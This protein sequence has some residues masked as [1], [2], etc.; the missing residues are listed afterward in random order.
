MKAGRDDLLIL[1]QDCGARL[2]KS[3]IREC[4]FL[5][6][7]RTHSLIGSVSVGTPF[8]AI[9]NRCDT[10]THGIIGAMCQCE[11]Q[12]IDID[13]VDDKNASSKVIDLF[14]RRDVIRASLG[15]IRQELSS[16][17]EEIV[18]IIKGSGGARSQ[19]L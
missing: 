1:E 19:S 16:R 4:D 13:I 17:I 14:E 2:L 15:T 12:I 3:L 11:D 9:T 18:G 5:V 8:A 7:E 6:G 10:R